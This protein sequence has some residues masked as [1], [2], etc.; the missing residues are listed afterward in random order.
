MQSIMI[1]PPPLCEN[2]T[3]A[4]KEQ[5]ITWLIRHAES[6]ANVG[7][8]KHPPAEI[9]LTLKGHHQAEQLAKSIPT[10]PDLIVI[11][12]FQ[13]TYMS[14]A[15][16]MHRWED[17][18]VETWPIQEL[19]Y[20][21]PIK[22]HSASPSQQQQMVDKYWQ[23]ADPSYCDG[24]GA[25]S[26]ADFI[27]RLQVFYQRLLASQGF[28]VVVGHGHFLKAFQLGLQQGFTASGNWMKQFRAREAAKPLMNGEII[29]LTLQQKEFI[30][31]SV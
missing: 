28:I 12:P 16:M 23:N 14:A 9:P 15:P 7:I 20:L 1:Q 27:N 17:V 5:L 2:F 18:P 25:E 10:C 3:M 6:T 8:F 31:A 21:S 4:S 29:K 19:T 13:R 22:Y 11:S 30:E 24:D 26:F